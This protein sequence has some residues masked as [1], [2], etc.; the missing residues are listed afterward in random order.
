M[1]T[2][3]RALR[4]ILRSPL[5]TGLLVAVLAV[6]I[7][8]TLITITVN[9]AF[10]ARLDEIRAHVGTNIDLNP[11]G[12]FRGLLGGGDPLSKQDIDKLASLQHVESVQR[13][14]SWPMTRRPTSTRRPGG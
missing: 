12:S 10:G 2:T 9:E 8:L 6:S 14:L 11:A 7:G 13:T 5:R 4:T 3:R 1:K